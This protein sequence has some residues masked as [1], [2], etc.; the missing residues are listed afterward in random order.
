[1]RCGGLG[2]GLA[3]LPRRGSVATLRG[4]TAGL[5]CGAQAAHEVCSGARWAAVRKWEGGHLDLRSPCAKRRTPPLPRTRT[6]RRPV[7]PDACPSVWGCSRSNRGRLRGTNTAVCVQRVQAFF[8][9][10]TCP[11]SATRGVESPRASCSGVMMLV[12]P[13]PEV[14]RMTPVRPELRA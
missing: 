10:H 5:H 2:G 6:P 4:Y 3:R 7:R 13:G 9:C 11:L 8:V 1:M 12:S 14:V